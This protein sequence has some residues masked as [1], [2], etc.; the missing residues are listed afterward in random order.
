MVLWFDY[1]FGASPA[2]DHSTHRSARRSERRP[3]CQREINELL[4]QTGQA[5]R[6]ARFRQ[7]WLRTAAEECPRTTAHRFRVKLL[8]ERMIAFRDSDGATA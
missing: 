2:P 6:W 7:Y 4:T 8:S 5:H 3:W 1:K